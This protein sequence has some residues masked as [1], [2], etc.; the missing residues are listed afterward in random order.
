MKILLIED[1]PFIARALCAALESEAHTVLWAPSG[2]EGLEAVKSGSPE[3]VLLDLGLPGMDGIDVLKSIR[4]MPR[5]LCDL[6]VIV[7]TARE[8][9]ESRLEGLD[10]GADDYVLKPFH[11]S[12]LLARLRA[13]MRRKAPIAEE[14]LRSGKLAL[15][16][17]T[18]ECTVG[19]TTVTLSKREYAL[20]AALLVR[21]G[22][23]LSRRALEEK[24]YAPGDEPEGNAIEYLIH[25]LRKKIGPG[26]IENIRGLGWRIRK[27]SA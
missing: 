16:T 1:D 9:L 2:P 4:A 7:V 20:L 19:G 8:A 6:P 26:F 21:P 27:E 12:E 15:N 14:V 13:V 11:T 25:V 22:A 5:P 24:L 23:I 3:A 18:H 17:V 10:A